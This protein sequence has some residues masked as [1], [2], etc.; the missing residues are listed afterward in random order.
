MRRFT[1]LLALIATL[2]LGLTAAHADSS[3]L[4]WY[5]AR[6]TRSTALDSTLITLATTSFDTSWAVPTGSFNP[7]A[8]AAIDSATTGVSAARLTSTPRNLWV[9]LEVTG[10]LQSQDSVYFGIQLSQGATS[11]ANGS[12]GDQNQQFNWRWYDAQLTSTTSNSATATTTGSQTFVY[13]VPCNPASPINWIAAP[14]LRVI[15]QGDTNA[16][17][18][19]F[20]T[21]G[22]IVNR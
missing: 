2:S 20:S 8:V 13:A 1:A 6:S 15:V 11:A 18:R 9:V 12:S 10:A 17:A 14:Y 7:T 5:F 19:A 16:A 21:R 4:H 3:L 22:W